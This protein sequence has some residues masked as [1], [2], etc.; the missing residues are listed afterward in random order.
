MRILLL[1]FIVSLVLINCKSKSSTEKGTTKDSVTVN[2]PAVDTTTKPV[3]TLSKKMSFEGYEEGDYAHLVFKDS[4]SGESYDFGHPEENNLGGINVVLKDTTA[5]FGYKENTALKGKL[6][7]VT[8]EK[9]M[10]NTYDGNGQPKRGEEW[11]I[12]NISM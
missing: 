5:S 10:V 9:K 11:R 3:S 1:S 7:S 12:T 2:T 8:M 4:E 6:F